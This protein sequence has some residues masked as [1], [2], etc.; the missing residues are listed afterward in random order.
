MSNPFSYDKP[1]PN[2]QGIP[3]TITYGGDYFNVSLSLSDLNQNPLNINKTKA[4]I[5]RSGFSTHT[6]NMGQR[7]VELD[8]TFTSNEDGSAILHV[9]QME[10][11]PAILGKLQLL[12]VGTYDERD[13]EGS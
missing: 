3:N 12:P 1:R 9:A 2:P 13:K 11:N 5:I 4:V 8:T 7:H 6:M 10:P